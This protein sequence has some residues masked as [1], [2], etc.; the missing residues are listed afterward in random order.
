ML[1]LFATLFST[2]SLA[3]FVPA[4]SHS[5][6]ADT[7]SWSVQIKTLGGFIGIGRGNVLVSSD[8]KMT[9]VKASP[10]GKPGRPCEGQIS[11]EEV[12]TIDEAVRLSKPD[13][14]RIS[15]LN[16]AAPDAY[17]YELE[18]IIDWKV[19]KLQWYDNAQDQLPEDLKKLYLTVKNATT[20][21]VKKC[22]E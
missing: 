19:H 21:A 9:Y 11:S 14:W 4:C 20:K 1:N 8:G 16:V 10:P 15:G 18:L 5:Q 6:P 17:G 7:P 2:L 13:Q 22:Q 12:R 3:M